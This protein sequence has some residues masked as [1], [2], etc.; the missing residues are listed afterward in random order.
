[1]IGNIG[2][3]RNFIPSDDDSIEGQATFNMFTVG[4]S[5]DVSLV[6]EGGNQITL[7]GVPAGLWI[8]CGKAIMIKDSGTS[9]TDFLVV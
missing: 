6:Q 4:T 2:T 1:M 3:A 7:T 8:P 9:A 5:G